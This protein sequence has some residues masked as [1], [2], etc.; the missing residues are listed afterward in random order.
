MTT[1][2]NTSLF[3]RLY[4]SRIIVNKDNIRIANVSLLFCIIAALVAPWLFIGSIIAATAPA[5]APTPNVTSQLFTCI[6]LPPSGISMP[7][8]LRFTDGKD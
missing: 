4:R 5:A 8:A 1:A 6:I 3:S 7:G 2:R